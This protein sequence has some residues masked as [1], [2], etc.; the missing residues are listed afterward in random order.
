MLPEQCEPHRFWRNGRIVLALTVAVRCARVIKGVVYVPQKRYPFPG[1]F[2]ARFVNPGLLEKSPQE[3]VSTPEEN[4][5][6]IA[7]F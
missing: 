3:V 1:D 6:L 4:I 7:S 5:S 2:Q